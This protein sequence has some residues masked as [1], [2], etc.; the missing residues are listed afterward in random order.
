[1]VAVNKSLITP[2]GKSMYYGDQIVCR[3]NPEVSTAYV[4]SLC[5]ANHLTK[6][7][8]SPYAPN[9]FV[10]ATTPLSPLGTL[11]MA[12]Y[13]WELPTTQWSHPNGRGN[14]SSHGYNVLDTFF[15]S[16]QWTTKKTI[17]YK[18]T[19]D[20]GAWEI[21]RGSA[22]IRVAVIDHGM[23][24]HEDFDTTLWGLY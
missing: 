14:V 15:H 5:Q 2:D 20:Y 17:G 22:S 7:D 13:L 19:S 12:N 4:D 6:L 24:A 21:T 11:D 23:E 8:T 9:Q 18:S 16:S 10:L 3:F 1:V